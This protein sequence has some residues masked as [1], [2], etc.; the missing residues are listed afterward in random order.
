[1]NDG[2]S[3]RFTHA[4]LREPADSC[5]HGIST[6]SERPPDVARF[7]EQ[8]DAYRRALEAA[9]VK[10]IVLAPLESFPDSVFVE[11]AALCF[12]GRAVILRPGARSRAGEAR[13]I[14]PHLELTFE[15]RVTFLDRGSVDGGDILLADDDA[16][17]GLSARTDGDGVEAL[18]PFLEGSGYTVRVARTPD[19]VLHFKSD[20]ALLDERTL[21]ATPALAATDWFGPG[22]E[23]IETPPGESAAANL[24]RV[25]D[26]VILRDGFPR[27]RE[28]L[29]SRGYHVV[30]VDVDEAARLDGGL[31]CLSLRFSLD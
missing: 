28:L 12:D 18:R 13:E 6:Q 23:V 8:H 27:T 20:C 17:I 31:S 15:G 14:A 11:D 21:F 4:V 26:H 22:F 30:A 16:F 25:N 9:G 7:R 29:E 24:V 10:T 19:G 2:R 5:V 3:F 1:M